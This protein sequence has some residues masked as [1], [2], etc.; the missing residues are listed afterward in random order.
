MCCVFDVCVC[1]CV[2]GWLCVVCLECGF[3]YEWGF[4]A[5]LC[6]F[7]LSFERLFVC[8]LDGVVWVCVVCA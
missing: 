6:A 7:V 5:V 4:F 3:H 8:V 1:M 2:L